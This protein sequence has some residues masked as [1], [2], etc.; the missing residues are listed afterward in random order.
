MYTLLDSGILL[1]LSDRTD[2]QF[3]AIDTAVSRIQIAG[4]VPGFTL[5]NAAEFW[6]TCTRPKTARG[7]LGLSLTETNR[8]LDVIERTFSLLADPP[9]LYAEWRQLVRTHGVMGKQVHDARLV[10]LMMTYGITHILTLNG[11]DFAR[12]PGIAVIDPNNP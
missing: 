7:G 12:Y 11:A 4:D 2:P 10:A 1:R 5:Q 8:R 9:S 3:A 6:N